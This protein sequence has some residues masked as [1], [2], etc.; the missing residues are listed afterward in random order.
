MQRTVGGRV[1]RLAVLAATALA[2]TGGGLAVSASP[3][4]AASGCS[5]N[6]PVVQ[7]WWNPPRATKYCNAYRSG[8]VYAIASQGELSG[9]LYAGTS[10]FV[11]Q[12]TGG[13]NPAVGS[14]H[15]NWWLYTQGDTAYNYGGW[16]WFPATM[17]SGG[18]N[19]QP[20]PGLPIC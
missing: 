19:Y 14:A 1:R 6:G 12:L 10:W 7:D 16:G 20:V 9:Y 4:A 18:G 17:V 2:L 3:A 11:C 15:N 5:G 8:Y 13:E